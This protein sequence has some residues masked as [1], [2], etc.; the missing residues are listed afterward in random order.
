[1]AEA[2]E[3]KLVQV[4]EAAI[5]AGNHNSLQGTF[6]Q[7]DPAED[8][9]LV[10]NYMLVNNII[11][12][13]GINCGL[14]ANRAYFVATELEGLDAPQSQMPGRKR[15]TMGTES[16]NT[17]TGTEDI[18]TPEGTTLKLIENGQLVIIRN[19]EKFNAQGQR[20]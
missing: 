16:E 12:K 8:N 10:G 6:T 4:G 11:K 9:I 17:A 14:Y 3:I 2:A 18:V 7:I 20:L 15:I 5:E 13:C 1:M 19:G